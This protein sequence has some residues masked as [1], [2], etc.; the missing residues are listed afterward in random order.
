MKP[1][2]LSSPLTAA[3]LFSLLL[4]IPAHS[5]DATSWQSND[6]PLAFNDVNEQLHKNYAHAKE[7]IRQ[8]LGP[9]I[10]CTGDSISLL[11]G[12]DK[13]TI[14]FIKPHYTGLKQIAHITLGSFIILTNHTDENLSTDTLGRLQAYKDGIEK[15]SFGLEKDQGLESGDESRQKELVNKTLS[16]LNTVI[17][18]KRVS[19]AD[20][21]KYVRSCTVP[22]LRNAYEAAGSQITTMDNA[23]AQWHKEMTPEEWKKLHVIIWTSHMPRQG[24]LAY[25]YFSKL[26]N[27]SQEGEQ[28]IVVESPTPSNDEL[29]IDLLLIHILDGKV[30]TNFFNDPWRM[31][32]DLLSDGAKEYLQKHKLIGN[33]TSN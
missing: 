6:K 21:Q 2:R 17:N 5:D 19:H 22:D 1:L 12:K 29:A 31:H 15:A 7:E 30:A 14:S 4:A 13:T 20:L 9:I 24:L 25:Q 28:L 11:K 8:A 3:I 10:L 26:L 32:R 18:D 27:L 33:K 16:F 23:V